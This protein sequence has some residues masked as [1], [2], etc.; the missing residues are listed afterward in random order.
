M[1]PGIY[2]GIT[3]DYYHSM[4]GIS[5]SG[6]SLILD[7]PARYYHEKLSGLVRPEKSNELIIGAAIDMKVFEPELFDSQYTVLPEEIKIKRGKV[8]D[9][10]MRTETRHIFSRSDFQKVCAVAAAVKRNKVFQKITETGLPQQ[11][12]IW[13]DENGVLLRARPDWMNDDFILDL[14]TTK[15]CHP[16]SFSKSV[17]EY[18]YHTQAFMQLQGSKII[19]KKKELTY[20]LQLKKKNRTFASLT[21]LMRKH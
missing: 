15:S 10:F 20:C 7:C 11:T 8:F 9:S 5:N 14:K 4:K 17:G 16:D 21:H 13:Q 3:N 2:N 19:T 12:I 6:I 18:N 1:K